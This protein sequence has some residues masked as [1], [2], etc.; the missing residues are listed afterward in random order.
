MAD[1]SGYGPNGVAITP[2]VG[3]YLNLYN[4]VNQVGFVSGGTVARPI[5]R[6]T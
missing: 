1:N 5:L 4:S 3:I 6:V 2:S